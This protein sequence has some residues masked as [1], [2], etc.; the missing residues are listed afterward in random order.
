MLLAFVFGMIVCVA[1]CMTAD[2]AHAINKKMDGIKNQLELIFMELRE[3]R[4]SR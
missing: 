4:K 1:I 3:L 2:K